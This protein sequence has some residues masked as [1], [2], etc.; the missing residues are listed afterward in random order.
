VQSLAVD[1]ADPDTVY[2]AATHAAVA[3]TGG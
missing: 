3:E 1:P 2:D